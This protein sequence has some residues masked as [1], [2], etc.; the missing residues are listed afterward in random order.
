MKP[1]WPSSAVR[2]RTDA[3]SAAPAGRVK[4]IW[5]TG[6]GPRPENAV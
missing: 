3:K 4:S 6:V 2:S 1:L 5:A